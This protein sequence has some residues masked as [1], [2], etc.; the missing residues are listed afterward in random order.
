MDKIRIKKL[1]VF[2]K[3]GVFKEENVLGQKFV[4]S[5]TLHLDTAKAG[6]SDALEDS[7]NYGEVCHFIREFA[8]SRTFQLLESLAEHTAAAVLDRFP[9]VKRIDLE[10][11]KPWAPIGLPL[12]SV[13]VEISR[14]WHQAFI[15]LGS[16]MGDKKKYLDDAVEA[17]DELEGCRIVTVADYIE[18]EPYGGVEQDDFLNSV[19]ELQ[20]RL[21]PQALLEK[22][23][24]IEALADRKRTVR[25]GPRTLDLDIIFYDDM[26][27]N[28]E[29]L[30]LPHPEMH[31]RGF[32]LEPMMQIAPWAY[33]PGLG[34]TVRDLWENLK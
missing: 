19:L 1:D 4:F 23:H 21:D 27:L 32:V 9:L 31:K 26:V 24:E 33:H 30:T 10:I 15:A 16:N 7:V 17:L 14:G 28:T 18:T 25:W 8:E 12:E 6:A 13:S 22:L 11:E 5:A 2:A 34:K 3:H 20:T 29:T